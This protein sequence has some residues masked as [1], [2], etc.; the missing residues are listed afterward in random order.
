MTTSMYVCV[1]ILDVNMNTHTH[2]VQMTISSSRESH[3]VER[4]G[5]LELWSNNSAPLPLNKWS[6]H[7]CICHYHRPCTQLVSQ[8]WEKA[9]K[10]GPNAPCRLSQHFSL[11]LL[12]PWAAA[13]CWQHSVEFSLCNP[14]RPFWA[15]N[16]LFPLKTHFLCRG[17]CCGV[18]C[19]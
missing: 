7:W 2:A 9:W 5:L 6:K 19:M 17:T 1:C 14:L 11:L 16:T 4:S 18:R 10:I 3:L 13:W 8:C 12:I 15:V